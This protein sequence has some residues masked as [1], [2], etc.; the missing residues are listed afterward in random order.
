MHD[1]G[2]TPDPDAALLS[3]D[4]DAF[5]EF[6][7]RHERAVLAYFR[8]RTTDAELVADL[9]AETF[10]QALASKAK[11]RV[12]RG[13]ARA[14]LFGIAGNVL[15]R[16]LRRKQVDDRARRKLGMQRHEFS[17]G[18][19]ER[20]DAMDEHMLV[21]D[22]LDGL[23]SEHRQAVLLRVLGDQSY[24]DIAERVQCSEALARQRVHRG[25]RAMRTRLEAGR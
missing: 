15:S 16:S 11:F 8:R 1:H 22:A 17:D 18:E 20:I 9:T 7:R 14:W 10:A 19:L 3:A 21:H 5:A 24:A 23:S 25:L 2:D 12:D 13:P 6:Y 4:G